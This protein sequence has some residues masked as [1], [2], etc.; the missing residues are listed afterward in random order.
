[1][2]KDITA[3][4]VLP[5]PEYVTNIQ[6]VTKNVFEALENFWASHDFKLIDFKLEFGIA[7][8]GM[9]MVADVIDND[10]WRLRDKN[11]NDVSKQSFRDGED[12]GTIEDKY[13]L[14]ASV[15]EGTIRAC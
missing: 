2:G 10:S 15:L 6:K 14:V 5:N 9:L 1:L 8:D 11:W 13:A 12:L 4:D 7:P 3:S